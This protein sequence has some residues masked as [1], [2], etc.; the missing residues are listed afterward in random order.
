MINKEAFNSFLRRNLLISLIVGLGTGIITLFLTIIFP[1]TNI[2]NAE[3]ISASW[4]PIMKDLFG[5]PIHAFTNIYGWLHLQIFH[6]TYWMVYSVLAAMLASRIVAIEV[7]KKTIDILLS[8]PLTR[9]QLIT[10]RFLALILI[11]LLAIVP[12][13]LGALTGIALLDFPVLWGKLIYTF[14][15]GFLLMLCAAA[16]TL[17]ISVFKPGQLFSLFTTLGLL[18]FMFL[19]TESLTKM[20]P[21]VRKISFLSLFNFYQPSDI[22]INNNFFVPDSIILFIISVILLFASITAFNKRDIYI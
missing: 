19:Y 14:L 5:D 1:A 22:L 11:L 18:A 13:F 6:I 16:L 10:S 7:E 9:T 4:P 21:F 12:T 17:L 2:E 20:I 8:T 3:A 15:I